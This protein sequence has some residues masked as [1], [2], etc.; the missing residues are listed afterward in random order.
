MTGTTAMRPEEIAH[1]VNQT[2]KARFIATGKHELKV[3]YAGFHCTCGDWR[4][5]S[6]NGSDAAFQRHIQR[7][8]SEV[9][10]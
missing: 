8:E 3:T 1:S 2:E 7:V 4:I 10:A 5:G 6:W 9:S